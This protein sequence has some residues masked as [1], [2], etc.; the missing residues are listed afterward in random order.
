M[1]TVTFVPTQESDFI[2]TSNRDESP[3]RETLF[4]DFYEYE[5]IRLLYPKDKLAGGSWIGVSEKQRLLCVL[6]GGF[7]FHDRRAQYRLSRGIVMKD[8]LVSPDIGAALETYYLDGIEPFTLVVIDWKDNLKLLELVWDGTKRHILEL[9]LASRIWSSSSLYSAEMKYERKAWF[10]EFKL[11]N[12]LD[13][14]SILEFHKTAGKGNLDYGAIID[15]EFV[16]TT[17]ITQVSKESDSVEMLFNNL[18]TNE[19]SR[20]N[21]QMLESVGD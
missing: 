14:N 21:L 6:N 7:T 10:E 4:P 3:L 20:T 17:S 18:A 15:R 8:L 11:A 19:V 13:K 12:E 1:C 9:P 5:N 16:K 2:L